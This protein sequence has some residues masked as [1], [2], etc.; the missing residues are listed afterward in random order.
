MIFPFALMYLIGKLPRPARASWR[1]YL[2][3]ALV[4]IFFGFWFINFAK[5]QLTGTPLVTF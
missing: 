2:I 5:D 4:A 3:L 1:S